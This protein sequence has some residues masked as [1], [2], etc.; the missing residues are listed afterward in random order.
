M[1]FRFDERLYP[2]DVPRNSLSVVQLDTGA[3]KPFPRVPRHRLFF[4]IGGDGHIFSLVDWTRNLS[5][6]QY[7]AADGDSVRLLDGNWV[8]PHPNAGSYCSVMPPIYVDG[9]LFFRGYNGL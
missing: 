5:D 4:S 3:V 8:P 2:Q 1:P 7:V 9:R 6:L